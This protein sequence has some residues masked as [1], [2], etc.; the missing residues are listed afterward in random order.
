MNAL[1][2]ERRCEKGRSL[3]NVLCSVEGA[4]KGELLVLGSV[5]GAAGKRVTWNCGG[6]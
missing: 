3:K 1:C 5:Q 2:S 6:R 4:A